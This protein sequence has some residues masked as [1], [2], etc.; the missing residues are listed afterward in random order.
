MKRFALAATAIWS[1]G[2]PIA[3]QDLKITQTTP[4][5][6]L[7]IKDSPK[8]QGLKLGMS[9]EQVS[10]SIRKKIDPAV[11]KSYFIEVYN[12]HAN[13]GSRKVFT[14]EPIGQSEYFYFPKSDLKNPK[15]QD[16]IGG[17][18]LAFFNKILIE[19]LVYYDIHRFDLAEPGSYPSAVARKLGLPD[20]YGW[21][22][23]S[24]I[25]CADFRIGLANSSNEVISVRVGNTEIGKEIEQKA[26]ESVRK[27][28][29]GQTTLP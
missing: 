11:V 13:L 3:G 22:E 20:K 5:C 29:R 16:T 2:L 27:Y 9:P 8:L 25:K 6:R 1:L 10:A 28:G 7:T 26:R 24:N 17:F 4:R 19:Y 14:K 12:P 15:S 23:G 18:R 21:S